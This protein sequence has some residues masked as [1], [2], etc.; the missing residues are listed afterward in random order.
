MTKFSVTIPPDTGPKAPTINFRP[1]PNAYNRIHSLCQ[2]E[3]YTVSQVSR[4]LMQK[5]WEAVFGEDI[6]ALIV[7][8]ADEQQ[9]TA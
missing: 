4:W 6:D 5:G 8:P 2:R 1:S 7:V 3:R 9:K